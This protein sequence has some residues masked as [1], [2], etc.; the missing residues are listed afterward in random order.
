MVYSEAFDTPYGLDN[1]SP[2]AN[3]AIKPKIIVV[4]DSPTAAGLAQAILEERGYIVTTLESALTL[5]IVA[6]EQEP[7]LILMDVDMPAID[8]GSATRIFKR[9]N[10]TKVV[11]HSS[12]GEQELAEIALRVGADGIIEKT[13]DPEKFLRQVASFL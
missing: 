8:G 12:K 13:G 4:D 3:P 10:S 5:S 2:D 11:L 7:D 6:G 1:K 9:R